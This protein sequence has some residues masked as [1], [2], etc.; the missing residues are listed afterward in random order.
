MSTKTLIPV[1]A[2]KLPTLTTRTTDRC[3]MEALVLVR[4]GTQTAARGGTSPS[5]PRTPPYELTGPKGWCSGILQ[6]TGTLIDM[7]RGGNVTEDIEMLNLS[8]FLCRDFFRR[9]DW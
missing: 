6:D 8:E 2:I 7:A 3:G 1:L 9:G 5:L 4:V